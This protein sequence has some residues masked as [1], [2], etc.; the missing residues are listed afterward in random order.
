M[1]TIILQILLLVP[2]ALTGQQRDLNFYLENAKA[3]SPVINKNKN[4][5][6]IIDLNLEQVRSILSKPEINLESSVLLAPIITHDNNQ[7]QFKLIS[8]DSNNYSG[9]DLAS[10]DGGQYQAVVSLKQPL[11]TGSKYRAYSDNNDISRQINENNIELTVHE[12]EQL[13]TYQYILCLKSKTETENYS[14]LLKELKD[15]LSIMTQL[16]ENGIY[17]Q[18]DLMLL[19]IEYQNYD[20][21][22]KTFQSEYRSNLYDLNLLC[23][24]SDTSLVEISMIDLQPDTDKSSDSRFLNSYTLDNL[25]ITTDQT[26]NELKYKPEVNLFANAGMNAVYLPSFNRFGFSTGITF[27]WNIFDGNQRKIQR[28]KSIINKA[29]IEFDKNNFIT[30]NN[31]NKNKILLQINSLDQRLVIIENQINQYSRLFDA[32]SKELSQG[33]VSVMDYKNLLKDIAAKKKESLLLKMDK[34]ILINSYNYWNY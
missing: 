32:Y 19:D 9:Y 15:Q 12:T 30:Q 7:N 10:T 31:I 5:N 22:F 20:I 11:F 33:E 26:I 25:Q 14:S 27:T 29:T 21:E 3:N 18:T 24:I 6:K 23:G 34:Q 2:V 4:D 13:V 16:V 1:K 17:K 8:E 28:E